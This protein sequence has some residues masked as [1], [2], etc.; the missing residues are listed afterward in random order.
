MNQCEG[1]ISITELLQ[2]KIQTKTVMD[3]TE[4]INS[5]GKAQ[6]E[7]IKELVKL[8]CHDFDITEDSEKI[9]RLT[10]SISVYVLEQSIGYMEYLRKE[11]TV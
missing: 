3:L 10:N 5:Q 11:S 8:R 4:W 9:D 6:Y 1:Q 7:Q 2:S